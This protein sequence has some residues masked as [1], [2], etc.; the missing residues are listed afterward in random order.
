MRIHPARYVL[1]ASSVARPASGRRV[2]ERNVLCACLL[3]ALCPSLAL[4]D[5]WINPGAG[6]W[7]LDSNWADGS[8]PASVD[9]ANVDNNG[10]ALIPSSGAVANT[11]TVGRAGAGALSVGSGGSLSSTLGLIGDATGALGEV[12]LDGA[13]SSWDVAAGVIV[14]RSGQGTLSVRN[15]G[16]LS[17]PEGFDPAVTYL[18]NG[19]SFV[20]FSAGRNGSVVLD[21]AGSV[22]NNGKN[23]FVGRLG[24]GSLLISGGA[25]VSNGSAWIGS[26]NASDGASGNA[27]IDGAGSTWTN[28]GNLVV[29][30]GTGVLTIQHG[31]SVTAQG[32]FIGSGGDSEGSLTVDGAGSTF[33]ATNVLE[34]GLFGHAMLSVKNGADITT[35]LTSIGSGVNSSGNAVVDGAGSVWNN[36]E[37]IGVGGSGN[38]TLT[39]QNLG[40]V[41]A[42]ALGVATA[43]GG[44]G[45]L[46]VQSGG[47][48]HGNIGAVGGT[49]GGSG[50]ALVDGANSIWT[51]GVLTV[52][53]FGTGSLGIRD[54]G[55]V[56]LGGGS[57]KLTLG[58]WGGDGTLSI[59][60]GP[61]TQA[62][63]LQAASVEGGPGVATLH[64]NHGTA[65]YSFTNNGTATGNPVF[66]T[67][68]TSVGHLGLG[69]TYLYGVNTYTGATT[70][71]G[72]VLR[73]EGSI[74]STS[75]ASVRRGT[76]TLEDGGEITVGGGAGTLYLGS[77]FGD[78]GMLNIGSG[79]MVGLLNAASVEGLGTSTYSYVTFNHD[80]PNYV[81]TSDGTPSA[82]PLVITGSAAVKIIG[83]GST[84]FPAVYT[85][86]GPTTV[87]GGSL[88]VS[89]AISNSGVLYVGASGAG[90]LLLEDNGS[91]NFEDAYIGN[92][93]GSDGS[94]LIDGPNATWTNNR[95]LF[96][97][98]QGRGTLTIRN[99]GRVAGVSGVTLAALGVLDGSVGYVTIDGAGSSWSNN[100]LAVGNGSLT[101]SD[102]GAVSTGIGRV[103]MNGGSG[104]VTVDGA[105]SKWTDMAQLH[106]GDSGVGTL[107]I[108]DGGVVSDF[109]AIIGPSAGTVGSVTV[110]GAGS[111]WANDGSMDV[112]FS[113]SGN[114]LVDNGATVNA[115]NINVGL[116]NFGTATIDGL[117][118]TLSARNILDVGSNG[119]GV[120]NVNGGASVRS[121]EG[122][123]GFFPMGSG[124]VTIDGVGSNWANSGSIFRIGNGSL[125]LRNGGKLA[126]ADGT[127]PLQ[128]SAGGVLVIDGAGAGIMNVSS[129]FA[130][131]AAVLNFKHDDANYAFTRDLAPDG[132]PV[133]IRGGTTVNQIGSGTTILTGA[134]SYT[135]ATTI[136][137]GTLRVNGSITSSASVNSGGTLGG[138][139]TVAAVS[140]ANGGTLAPGNSVGT[141]TTGRLTL[142]NASL[143]NYELGAPG[144]GASDSLLVNGDLVLDGALNVQAMPGFAV[145]T[146]RVI[147][148]SGALVNQGLGVTGIPVGYVGTVDVA[149][150]GQVNL[151]VTSSAAPTNHPP[152]GAI[153]ITG[154]LREGSVVSAT[155]T[156]ADV[157]GLGAFNYQWFLDD[158][159][160]FGATGVTLALDDLAVGK[161]VRVVVS[162]T[163]GQGFAEQ[164]SSAAVGPVAPSGTD[165]P[166][167][168]RLFFVNPADNVNQQTFIR[169]VNPNDAD[170]AV[171][172]QGFDDNGTPAPGG[173]VVLVISAQ[174]SA[175][176]NAADLELGN[177]GKGMDGALGNGVG[178]WQLKV[179][180]AAPIEAMSL[181]RTPD[182]F[183]TSVTETAPVEAPGEHVLYFAN[184][185]SNPNQQSFIRVVNRGAASGEV[186]VSAVDDAGVPAAGG[187]IRFTLAANAALN[188]N[189]EDYT[190]G[191]PAKGLQGAFGTGTGK[192]KL[193]LTS[194]SNLEVMSLIRTPDGFLT[195]LSNIAP[196]IASNDDSD[197][198]LLSVNPGNNA[199]QQSLIRLVNGGGLTEHVILSGTDDTGVMAPAS[200]GVDVP[201]FGAVQLLGSDLEQGN[202]AKGLTGA[203]GSGQGRWQIS[204][205]P[206]ARVEA[207]SLLRVPGGFLTNLSAS[208]P[209]DSRFEARLWIFN[210]GS[211]DQQRSI[212]RLINRSDTAGVALIE[213]I[214]DAGQPA[215]GGSATVNLAP[216][217]A[218]ELSAL[219]LEIGSAAK[220]LIG[221]LGDGSGK[222]RLHV[223]ADVDIEVQGLLETPTGFLTNLSSTVH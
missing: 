110:S 88:T 168:K 179:N 212:L 188:F 18:E 42:D 202:P 61:G 170:V 141:L 130:S 59:G 62:G 139:G 90:E 48:V 171:Q 132:P 127:G 144:V 84:L 153:T 71:G 145:G 107:W 64:F 189:A 214:D 157:D 73:V 66:I 221:A 57:G 177:A 31:G 117:Q 101:I 16:V 172:I 40:V 206:Q 86:T 114:L 197:R 164:V 118:S 65:N 140:V 11:L 155:S 222:W 113:G 75:A 13:G 56:A 173:D 1:H 158:T 115:H 79:G 194:A 192:W 183:L 55:T 94:M 216:R 178:K 165:L 198:L 85:Y 100:T 17:I 34:I 121:V 123:V 126:I 184:P 53:G 104:S 151:V 128:L 10:L 181:I 41:T 95:L 111:T 7:F 167:Q 135:G 215:P 191:S 87:D 93:I 26:A 166:F 80:N 174:Q 24:S 195:D 15:G 91:I 137:A 72:G 162:Y 106:V 102:G 30:D 63:V 136:N 14:G 4:A 134:H 148:Y 20:G 3:L 70:V 46:V 120:V 131:G 74:T 175:Q 108:R 205:T 33:E 23:L 156:L 69:T 211:N 190:N 217:A 27:I 199:I 142:A 98:R 204:V 38:G 146:Y 6:D 116:F 45:Q 47:K 180:S 97:G 125:T 36:S 223:S 78:S 29:G 209:R 208:A 58:Q 92:E 201:P 22:W 109:A 76:L 25:L 67:G 51:L 159:A 193:T 186:V 207:Q 103:G 37:G 39:V 203:F 28:R 218:V 161:R 160:E 112:G 82:A 2:A 99:G 200:V 152:T 105:G 50:S 43:T 185:G 83:S 169:L 12:T 138:S 54:G 21:G 182:G 187:D 149:T 35:R 213:A 19:D 81:F 119:S 154:T 122:R 89:G 8:V 143:L 124:V 163:D 129:I 150:R 44:A 219:E 60:T 5:D 52:G 49:A 96:V 220:G 196:R 32:G 210:P 77:V 133:L 68:N 176:L 9:D 147:S